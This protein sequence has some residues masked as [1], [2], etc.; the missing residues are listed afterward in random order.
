M[1]GR[2]DLYDE[3]VY[4]DYGVG[5]FSFLEED[6]IRGYYV[7]GVQTCAL[8]IWKNSRRRVFYCPNS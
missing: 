2:A 3:E 6:G 8:P 7:T 5:A 1:G 4:G